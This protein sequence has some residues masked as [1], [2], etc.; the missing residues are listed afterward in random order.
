MAAT[1]NGAAI[2]RTG[3]SRNIRRRDYYLR[4]SLFERLANR[5]DFGCHQGTILDLQEVALAFLAIVRRQLLDLVHHGM[6]AGDHRFTFL[7]GLGQFD[8][9]RLDLFTAASYSRITASA[10]RACPPD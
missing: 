5:A 10:Q 2:S 1:T 6:N 4:N 3:H 8:T 9:E 7:G